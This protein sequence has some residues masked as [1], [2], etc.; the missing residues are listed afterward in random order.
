VTG[1]GFSH[2]ETVDAIE[3]MVDFYIAQREDGE[4]FVDAYRRLGMD[5]FKEVLY[6]TA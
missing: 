5:A 2:D 6:G 1:K 4:R 3:K